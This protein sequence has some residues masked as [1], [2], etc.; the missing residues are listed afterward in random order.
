MDERDPFRVHCVRHADVE[1][2]V[3]WIGDLLREESAERPTRGVDPTD[4]LTLVPAERDA[5]V[6]VP[7]TR[8][9]AG[10]LRSERGG[11]HIQ[12]GQVGQGQRLVD[13][14]QAGLVGQ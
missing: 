12:V 10:L 13:D 9:P 2:K 7:R 6:A 4:E 8:R 1:L 14:G 5:V 3:Q 11:E